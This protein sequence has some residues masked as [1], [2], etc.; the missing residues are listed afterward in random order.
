M[1]S[2]VSVT[3]TLKVRVDLTMPDDKLIPFL[4]GEID[5]EP[6]LKVEIDNLP[7]GFADHELDLST[8]IEPMQIDH[9]SRGEFDDLYNWDGS[10]LIKL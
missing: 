1:E 8:Y 3:Y 10:K 4:N 5:L 7:D 9:I 6:C 2:T